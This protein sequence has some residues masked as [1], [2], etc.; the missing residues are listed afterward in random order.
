MPVS[1]ADRAAYAKLSDN[2]RAT[3][4]Q[5]QLKAIRE[6]STGPGVMDHVAINNSLDQLAV[7]TTKVDPA[8][9]ATFKPAG[10]VTPTFHP[11]S[12][13]KKPSK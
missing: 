6:G 13:Q 12:L 7:L 4:V 8:P 5:T 2:D 11:N 3:A 10:T 9:G 1:D